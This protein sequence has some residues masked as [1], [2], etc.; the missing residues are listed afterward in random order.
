MRLCR[1]LKD[2]GQLKKYNEFPYQ[3]FRGLITCYV[4]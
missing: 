1:G 4:L 2:P 3:V